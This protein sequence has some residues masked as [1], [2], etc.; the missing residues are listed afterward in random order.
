VWWV[1]TTAFVEAL[2]RCDMR[3]L[4]PAPP[5]PAQL[6][7]E[8]ERLQRQNSIYERVLAVRDAMLDT[9]TSL[10]PPPGGLRGAAGEQPMSAAARGLAKA[11]RNLPSEGEL[12]AAEPSQSP[13]QQAQQQGVELQQQQSVTQPARTPQGGAEVSQSSGTAAPASDAVQRVSWSMADPHRSGVASQLD[14]S[15]LRESQNVPIVS[16]ESIRARV[17]AMTEPEHLVCVCGGGRGAMSSGAGQ[18]LWWAREAVLQCQQVSWLDG[19]CVPQNTPPGLN[20]PSEVGSH[21][22]A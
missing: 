11:I 16:D 10:H 5:P 22:A 18:G 17:V 9:F 2:A 13:S 7:D 3:P 4:P 8:N 19:N 14:G 1:H 20:G 6:E 12:D 15:A 21:V